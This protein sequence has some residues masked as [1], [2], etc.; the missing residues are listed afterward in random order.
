MTMVAKRSNMII[1]QSCTEIKISAPSIQVRNLF[2]T[3]TLS[4]RMSRPDIA[5]NQCLSLW[6]LQRTQSTAMILLKTPIIRRSEKSQPMGTTIHPFLQK[7]LPW[8]YLLL[9][10]LMSPRQ[11]KMAASAIIT[12][13]EARQ[14]RPS[15]GLGYLA[16]EEV[17]T[18]EVVA[19]A[20]A[21]GV[22]LVCPLMALIMLATMM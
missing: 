1:I 18:E 20:A 8:V 7:W 13:Q 17:A 16:Q 11:T 9:G 21:R 15:L 12:V 10:K 22:P 6:H 5:N 14:Y 4:P 2:G 3:V 19:D